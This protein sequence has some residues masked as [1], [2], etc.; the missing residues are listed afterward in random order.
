MHPLISLPWF[1]A[2]DLLFPVEHFTEDALTWLNRAAHASADL[3]DPLAEQFC[4]V[5]EAQIAIAQALSWLSEQVPIDVPGLLRLGDAGKEL[6]RRY[7]AYGPIALWSE[8]CAELGG[9][10]IAAAYRIGADD[11]NTHPIFRLRYPPVVHYDDHGPW[12][13]TP[14][15]PSHWEL[16]IE[17]VLLNEYLLDA[18]ARLNDTTKRLQLRISA[19]TN[20]LATEYTSLGEFKGGRYKPIERKTHLL[21]SAIPEWMA[22][23][24]FAT[25]LIM[26]QGQDL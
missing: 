6:F 3:Q 11:N 24:D 7:Q 12:Q 2:E 1:N 22:N 21:R 15:S 17:T 20:A 13:L 14:V 9:Q 16:F 4:N 10:A 23:I 5:T 19:N 18:K 26:Q 25:K 8:T